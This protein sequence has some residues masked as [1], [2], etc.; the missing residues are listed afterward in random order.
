VL[1]DGSPWAERDRIDEVD[2]ALTTVDGDVVYDG[3]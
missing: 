3:R 2:V 1:L